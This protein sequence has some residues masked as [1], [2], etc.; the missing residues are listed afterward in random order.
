M[1]RTPKLDFFYF[2]R[3]LQWF[4]LVRKCLQYKFSLHFPEMSTLKVIY[5]SNVNLIT[6]HMNIAQSKHF[7][8]HSCT[9]M[10]WLE[11]TTRWNGVSTN[12][13]GFDENAIPP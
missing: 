10:S 2:L 7:V 4:G 1:S 9:N 13:P 8:G 5:L 11:V 6:L 3:Y 12:F